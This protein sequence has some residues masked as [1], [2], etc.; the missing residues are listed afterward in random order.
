MIMREWE[1]RLQENVVTLLKVMFQN[2]K[3]RLVD[4]CI[5]SGRAPTLFCPT[6]PPPI[7][8]SIFSQS[9]S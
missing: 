1:I 6:S 8:S 4:Q 3:N 7:C 9:P 2:V 5:S